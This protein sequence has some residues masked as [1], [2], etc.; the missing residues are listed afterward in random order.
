VITGSNPTTSIYNASAVNAYNPAG[1]LPRFENKNI[2][3]F[4]EKALAY[5]NAGVV[6]VN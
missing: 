5:C 2:V 3:F 6:A 4:F 1:S